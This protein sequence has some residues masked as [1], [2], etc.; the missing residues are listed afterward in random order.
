MTNIKLEVGQ[1]WRAGNGTGSMRTIRGTYYIDDV[2]RLVYSWINDGDSG[3]CEAFVDNFPMHNTLIQHA[4][5]APH[6]PPKKY[7]ELT[8]VEAMR[9]LADAGEPVEC[10]FPKRGPWIK[11]SLT[12]VSLIIPNYP[13]SDA[14]NNVYKRCRI[15]VTND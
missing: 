8:P 1:V 14:D 11:S 10:E 5:G 15:E 2:E 7:K 3:V 13:F 6:T 4:D 9:L 12:G